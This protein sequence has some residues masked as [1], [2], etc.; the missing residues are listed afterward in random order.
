[1]SYTCQQEIIVIEDPKSCNEGNY[2]VGKMTDLT[3]MRPFI[4]F[5]AFYICPID[6]EDKNCERAY[7]L[8]LWK[9]Y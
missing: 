6:I 4:I 1:M 3:I 5:F 9:L 2:I 7:K 8:T